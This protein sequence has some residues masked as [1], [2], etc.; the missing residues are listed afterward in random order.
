MNEMKPWLVFV[1]LILS[2]V[3]TVPT[4]MAQGF[5]IKQNA[6]YFGTPLKPP[7]NVIGL[8]NGFGLKNGLNA[9]RLGS[10]QPRTLPKG[11]LALISLQPDKIVFDKNGQLI[12]VSGKLPGAYKLDIRSVNNLDACYQ[13]LKAISGALEINDPDNEFSISRQHSDKLGINH[14]RMQQ[15]YRGLPVWGAEA[16]L[17]SHGEFIDVYNGRVF[18]TPSRVDTVPLITSN[19]AVKQVVSHVSSQTTYKVLTTFEKKFLNYSDPVTSLIIYHKNYNPENARLAWH[20]TV[21]PNFL[22]VWEYFVD[23]MTGEVIHFY[24]NTRNDGD[25]PAAGV[26]L[27]GI[28]RNFHANLVSGTYYLSDISK[29]MYDSLT[30]EGQI[31]IFSAGLTN[32][33]AGNFMASPVVSANNSWESFAVSAMYNSVKTWDYFHKTFDLNSYNDKGA[34]ISSIVHVGGLNGSGFDNAFWNGQ[35]I[36]YGDGD[37]KFKPLAGGLDVGAHEHGHAYEQ[38][39]SML[40]YQ[41]QSGALAE[42]FADITGA[43]VERQ[44][45]TIGEQV[46]KLQYFPT[47]CLRDMSNPHNG[48]QSLTDRGWQPAHMSEIYTGANDNGGVHINCGIV[49]FAFFKCALAIGKEKAEQIFWRASLHYLTRTAQFADCREACLQAAKDLYGTVSY[50]EISVANAF[51]EVGIGE[52]SAIGGVG[53]GGAPRTLPFNPGPDYLLVN[54]IDNDNPYTLHIAS[55]DGQLLTPVSQTKIFN[56]PGVLDDGSQAVFISGDH[57][58]R[59]VSLLQEPQEI[60]IQEDTIWDGVSVEKLGYR[61]SAVTTRIDSSIHV[62]SFEKQEWR[63]FK[64][65]NPGT[66]PGVVTY[67]VLYADEMDWDYSGQYIMYDAY[68]R[69]ESGSGLYQEFWD[70]NFIKV[71]DNVSNDWGDGSIMKLFTGLPQGVSIG[72][73]SF[74]KNSNHIVA[75]DMLDQPSGLV[76]IMAFN[77][78]DGSG[79]I[80]YRNDTTL[81]TPNYSKL[82]DKLIFNTMVDHRENIGVI[83]LN[84]DK[85]TPCGISSPLIQDAKWG[86]WFAQG[87]RPWHVNSWVDER[88]VRVYPNPCRGMATI[89]IEKLKDEQVTVTVFNQQ[90]I[91]MRSVSLFSNGSLLKVDLSD[92]AG[93]MYLLRVNG[94]SFSLGC[95]VAVW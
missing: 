78:N 68:S 95:K 82:D 34:S 66:Q 81:G 57:K 6:R 2:S 84:P 71:W 50:E 69:V 83:G 21:R 67:N 43:M 75:F 55:T 37:T 4:L 89:S 47:G 87:N 11:A 39:A 32:P 73:P 48:G 7:G 49:N 85:V 27:N 72:N 44:N 59:T 10:F 5:A 52:G 22:E 61:I 94:K 62:Y 45:W 28:A 31:Q 51:A 9:D 12:F 88:I 90:G 60:I 70:V 16:C 25:V 38:V 29:T 93:G 36:F 35:A 53:G 13:Y 3:I 17:H 74:S 40:E 56:K 19:L 77:I 14:Y 76:D 65:F 1:S 41:N 20:V 24:N 58:I 92:L 80:V 23:A 46:V 18:P 8:I 64:L 54:N 15:M 86:I 30:G 26:D 63:K 33:L 42:M 79:G 91:A